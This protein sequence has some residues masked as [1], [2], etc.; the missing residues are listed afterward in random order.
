M[1]QTIE[2]SHFDDFLAIA[3]QRPGAQK[4]LLAFA[5]RELP[6]GHTPAQRRAFERGQG[7]HLAPRAAVDKAP[8]HLAGFEALAAEADRMLP[9]WDAVFVTTM[10]GRS[11]AM[12]EPEVI[13]QALDTMIQSIRDGRISQYLV[14]DRQG[15][16][17]ILEPA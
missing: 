9:E 6:E 4:L 1:N 16:P 5:Q 2:L 14:F 7:G 17:L 11:H 8:E 3:R 10:S 15:I 12:P 13:N